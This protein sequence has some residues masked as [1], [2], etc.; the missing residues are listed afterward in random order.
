MKARFWPGDSIWAASSADQL[1]ATSSIRC[2]S[3][4]VATGTTVSGL[5]VK[6]AGYMLQ[7][8]FAITYKVN[9]KQYTQSMT[10]TRAVP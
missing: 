7:G 9:N 4:T 2:A 10:M 3:V 5:Q 8:T 6:A 1:A